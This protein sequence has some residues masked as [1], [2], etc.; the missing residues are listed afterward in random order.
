MGGHTA[1]DNGISS[2]G[3]DYFL[4]SCS[5]EQLEE[6]LEAI[7]RIIK[8]RRDK[9]HARR[10]LRSN[11]RKN[12]KLKMCENAADDEEDEES[13]ISDSSCV[14]HSEEEEEE[15]EAKTVEEVQKD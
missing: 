14:T 11:Q 13:E 12:K 1:F 2:D 10:L 9:V 6:L 8:R 15:E 7:P 4:M 5:L 3:F